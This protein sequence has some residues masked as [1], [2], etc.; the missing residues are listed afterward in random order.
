MLGYNGS[1][2]TSGV[3]N[4]LYIFSETSR[5]TYLYWEDKSLDDL[6]RTR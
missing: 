4:A 1:V 3:M 5:K 2:G 6:I